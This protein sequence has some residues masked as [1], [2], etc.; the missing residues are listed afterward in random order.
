[1]S[2]YNKLPT[3]GVAGKHNTG[4]IYM[5]G[6]GRTK[7]WAYAAAAATKN[8]L[9]IMDYGLY[10]VENL[11]MAAAATDVNVMVAEKTL[12]TGEFGWFVVQGEFDVITAS[13]AIATVGLAWK[14]HTDGT[15]LCTDAAA[16][17]TAIN[18]FAV[19]TQVE[20]T[21][22]THTMY[23]MGLHNTVTWS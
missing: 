12:S 3:S 17:E 19:G 6:K 7:V 15:A 8:T 21:G 4:Q 16:S 14:I 10:G 18:E 9:Y 23:L 11:A 13:D 1:M 5:D 22:T 2:Y 20:A